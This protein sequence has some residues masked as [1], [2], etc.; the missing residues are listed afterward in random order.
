MADNSTLPVSAGTEVFANKDMSGVKFPK[1]IPSDGTNL[2]TIKP[3]STAPVA[4]DTGLVVS[5]HPLSVLPPGPALANASSPVVICSDQL[6]I[7]TAVGDGFNAVEG[8]TTSAAVAAGATGSISA[9]LRSISRDLVANVSLA[10]SANKIGVVTTDQ[11]THGTTDLV[12]ADITK[13]AGAAIA[14][15]HGTAATALRVELPTD[16]TGVVGLAAGAALVGIVSA[17]QE[18][19]TIYNGTTAIVPQYA[20]IVASASGVTNIVALTG[21]KMIRVIAWEVKVNAAVNFKWQ[22]H[23]AG[24]ITGLYYN[25]GQG[26]GVARALNQFGYFQTAVGEALDINLSGAVAVGGSLVYV[27]V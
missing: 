2:A 11:T 17:S 23:V 7:A 18:T 14:Q 6:A 5:I 10:A 19:S 27:L 20:K 9:K 1:Q 22:S 3:A 13:V 15:G 8:A 21:G 12:A 16:G 25:S 24:D 4:G 26:D